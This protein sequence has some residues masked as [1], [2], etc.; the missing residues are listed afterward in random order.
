MLTSNPQ[1]ERRRHNST[2]PVKPK[3]KRYD[4]ET[5]LDRLRAKRQGK[6]PVSRFGLRQKPIGRKG[7]ALRA[8]VPRKAKT[9]DGDSARMIKD[10]MDELVRKI[11]KLRDWK[12]VT[13]PITGNLQVGHLFRRGL[14]SVRWNL[15]NC[16]AQCPLCNSEH[17][18]EPQYYI[19]V[20]IQRHGEKAY[21]ALYDQSRSKHKFTYI[22]LLEIRDG[23]RAELNRYEANQKARKA[24]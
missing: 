24:A 23:L 9:V 13:C 19:R 6:K 11:I 15:L 3:A 18:T 12:C 20:F 14:E 21:L 7:K 4:Y 17:E 2:F 22:E 5:A 16:N 1:K 8:R 10:E